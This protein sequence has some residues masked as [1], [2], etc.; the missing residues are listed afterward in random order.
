[1]DAPCRRT[2]SRGGTAIR[3]A[4]G[5]ATRSSSKP[6]ASCA[7]KILSGLARHAYRGDVTPDDLKVLQEFYARGREEGGSF[8]SG[9]DLALRRILSSPKFVF[10]VERDPAAVAN[11]S[12]YKL[13]DL[14]VASRLSF[15]LWSTIPDDQLLA[16]AEKGEVSKPAVLEQQ[17]R[18]MIAAGSGYGGVRGDGIRIV[19]PTAEGAVEACKLLLD[20]GVDVDAFNNA[21][22]TALHAAITR[23]DPVV[24]F[25]ASRGATLTLKNKAGVTPLDIAKGNSGRGGRGGGRGA[26]VVRESTVKLLE[27]LIRESE[28]KKSR[29]Q[30]A[31]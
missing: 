22:N 30:A 14:E 16:L 20:R 23:G 29:A 11:G 9:I 31:P 1:M 26:P 3:S 13:S 28:A 2:P 6:P 8:D 24:G 17:V 15:F 5:K 21:G 4:A 7:R 12:V 25:L 18:R 19:V 27:Q 10:R